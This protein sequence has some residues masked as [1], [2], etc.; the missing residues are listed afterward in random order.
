MLE[1][2]DLVALRPGTGLAPTELARIIGR[3]R[4]RKVKAGD[5]LQELDL[6]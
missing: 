2:K 6:V 1:K 3:L 5:V 4:A